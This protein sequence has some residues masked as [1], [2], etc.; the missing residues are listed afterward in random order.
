MELGLVLGG[1]G[2][3]GVAWEVG[4]LAGLAD[5]LGWDPDG[6]RTIV[7]TSAGSVIGANLRHG[8]SIDDL[9]AEQRAGGLRLAGGEPGDPAAALEVFRRWAGVELMDPP[10]AR[11]V[12]ELA[13]SASATD[14]AVMLDGFRKILPA[15]NWPEGDLRVTGVSVGTGE[16][17]VWTAASGV[18]LA[19][20]VTASCA[21]PGLFPPITVG[22]DRYVDGGL[23]SGSNADVVA[24][25]RLG[26][27]LFIGPMGVG[28]TGLAAQSARALAREVDVL[29]L[30]GT[31][32]HV[33]EPGERF[34]AAAMQLMDATRRV[35]ALEI[36]LAEGTDAADRLRPVLAG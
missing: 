21:V 36:G 35:E 10:T 29:T 15:A 30:D 25:D 31:A 7:G 2:V 6:A 28:T 8:R 16:R 18:E 3:V 9:V 12:G 34:V 32:L 26:A 27:A 14:E 5:A 20:A 17:V 4:V 13:M 19:A 23:W 11:A 33:L 24:G 22:D 1:G